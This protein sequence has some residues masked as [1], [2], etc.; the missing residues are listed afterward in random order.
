MADAPTSRREIIT[1]EPPEAQAPSDIT[2]DMSFLDHLEEL[3]W[4]I[5]K[6]FLG[7]LFGVIVAFVFSDWI[8]EVLLLGPAKADFVVY[9]WL[10]INAVDLELQNRRLPGQFFTYWGTLLI[11]GVIIGSPILFY[12]LWAFVAPALNP[13]E[14]QGTRFTVFNITSLF[15]LGILFG[16]L[17]LTPFAL[18]F[19]NT[20]YISDMVR[21]DF[22]INAY[23]SSITLWT[24]SCGIIF[25]LPLVSYLLSKMG[26][27]TPQVMIQY[28][29]YAILTCFILAAFLTPPDPVSQFLIAIPLIILYQISIFISRVTNRRRDRKIWGEE[30]H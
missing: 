27:L 4:R 8:M 30:R 5:I 12:Q 13:N 21:N 7:I 29:K 6:G 3:R 17:V 24:L 15:I 22:D 9:Q 18:Q 20:F 10:G 28:R 2:S 1:G 19:F 25:Q 26:L 16:Y 14:Q 11:V 23:F